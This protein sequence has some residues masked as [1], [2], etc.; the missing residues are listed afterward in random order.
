MTEFKLSK[1]IEVNR[2]IVD[3]C[4]AVSAADENIDQS[5]VQAILK[6]C[7]VLSVVPPKNFDS[8]NSDPD[9]VS[10]DF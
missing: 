10:Q 6:I 5:E 1:K 8:L 9:Y 7:D 4:I 3:M 2:L